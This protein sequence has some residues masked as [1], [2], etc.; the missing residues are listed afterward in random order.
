MSTSKHDKSHASARMGIISLKIVTHQRDK[1]TTTY[2][3]PDSL[4]LALSQA[5]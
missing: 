5:I 4:F 2:T 1:L 3:W